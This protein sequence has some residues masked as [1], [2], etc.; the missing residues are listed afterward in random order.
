M[1]AGIGDDS[2]E[3]L[4]EITG[5]ADLTK[6]G[7]GTLIL[8][9]QY[10][11]FGPPHPGNSYTGSTTISGG[12]LQAAE[13]RGLPFGSPIVLDG[14]IFQGNG[15][16]SLTRTLGSGSNALEWTA[17]GGG[18]SANGGD[19]TVTIG[20]PGSGFVQWGDTVGSQLIG[21]LMFGSNTANAKTIFNSSIDLNGQTRTIDVTA[22]LGGDAA[23]LAGDISDSGSGTGAVTK[24]GAGT[25]ILTAFGEYVGA[26]TISGGT[27][28][29][30]DGGSGGKLST[31]SP[32]VDNANF[33]INR[34]DI[35]EQG[36]DFSRDPITGSGSFTNSGSGTTT[37]TAANTY[38][39]TTF[40]NAG[41]LLVNGST[42]SATRVASGGTLGGIGTLGG[43]VSNSGT[44]NPGSV[45]TVGSLNVTGDVTDSGSAVWAVDVN[46]TN[47]DKL[48]VVGAITL[49]GS[50]KLSVTGEGAGTSW[51]IATYT[52]TET[53]TFG[54][55]NPWYSVTYTGGQITL[56]LIGTP[57][58]FSGDGNV[59]ASDF[60][61]MRNLYPNLSTGPGLASYNA[62]RSHFG[63]GFGTGADV[64]TNVPEPAS[65]VTAAIGLLVMIVRHR[66][67]PVLVGAN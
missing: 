8:N 22:G 28:Q 25:L 11:F 19:L 23:V 61:L 32:I 2:V 59:D 65:S 63:T 43:A 38:S 66:G 58:D 41:T 62:W 10:L 55:V 3:M 12:V 7:T 47:A 57:G 67:L 31:F 20:G 45:G 14:G 29:L 46:G 9:P 26:T 49:S 42:V 15:E 6:K 53:G 35:V 17:K 36:T 39:G 40:V 60:V 30:G 37:L 64:I 21:T 50:D 34:R 1:T 33:A 13:G 27:L 44:I 56:H 54:L 4:G 51:V 48:S 18:F 16:T 52:T 24:T 5:D